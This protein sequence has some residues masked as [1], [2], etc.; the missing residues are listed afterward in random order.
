MDESGIRKILSRGLFDSESVDLWDL[1][2]SVRDHWQYEMDVSYLNSAR[3]V[4]SALLM[5]N[6]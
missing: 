6:S 5:H 4:S 3:L 2:D 1:G